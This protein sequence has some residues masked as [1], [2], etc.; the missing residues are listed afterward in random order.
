MPFKMNF[1]KEQL[2]KPEP[3]PNDVYTL[4]L[5]GFKPKTAKSGESINLN[6]Q[7]VVVAPGEKHDGR[8]MPYIFNGNSSI[9]SFLQDM[10]HATGE[11]MEE[12]DTPEDL[13]LPG[14]FDNDPIKFDPQKPETWVY[15]GPLLNKTLKAEL[16]VDEYGNKVSRFLCDIP[17]CAERFPKIQHSQ[18]MNKKNS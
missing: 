10:C 13:S 16:T 15:Q 5:V 4:R 1:D 7:F 3:L 14:T 8:K 12:G 6:P 17:N 9:P 18:N 2:K 11:L